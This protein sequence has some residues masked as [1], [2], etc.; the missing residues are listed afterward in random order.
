MRGGAIVERGA[1]AEVL[2]HP[3]QSY[4]RALRAAA[5][6]PTAMVGVKPRNVLHINQEQGV[7]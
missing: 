5:L 6:D 1:S 7:A 4:T 2:A 3:Q